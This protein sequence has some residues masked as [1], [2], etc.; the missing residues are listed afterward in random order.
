MKA[1]SNG[2]RL[3]AN[4][5]GL[6]ARNIGFARQSTLIQGLLP[7]VN[8][9]PADLGPSEKD[10]PGQAL[11]RLCTVQMTDDQLTGCL[12]KLDEA[13]RSRIKGQDALVKVMIMSLVLNEHALLEGLPGVGKTEIVKWIACCT[14]LPFSRVQFIPDML[15]SDLIGKDH[16]DIVQLA[17]LQAV[18][19]SAGG[20]SPGQENGSTQSGAVRWINGPIFSSLVLADEINRAPSK[21]QAALLEAMGEKQVTPF[22]KAS[23]PLFSSLHQAALEYWLERYGDRGLLGVPRPI[24]VDRTDLAQFTVFATMNPIEQEGTYPLSEAQIDRFCFKTIVPYPGRRHYLPIDKA[25]YGGY[26][27]PHALEVNL[28][29]GK[30][31]QYF[32]E[33]PR[34]AV[35]VLLPL[36]FFLLCRAHI[37]PVRLGRDSQLVWRSPMFDPDRIRAE[38]PWLQK[39]HDIVYMSNA[40][41]ERIGEAGGSTRWYDHEQVE[42]RG[43]VYGD[44]GQR[45][46]LPIDNRDKLASVFEQ[47]HTQYVKSG[48][49]PRGFLK[50]LSAT[51]CHALLSGHSEPDDVDIATVVGDVLRHRVHMDVHARLAGMTSEDVVHKVCEILL[52]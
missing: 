49:S 16:I 31:R 19:Q 4:E 6:L 14:G 48:G 34:D 8:V 25:V 52:G 44:D 21:V 30:C 26:E 29:A 32:E 12:G 40:R 1:K 18:A 47:E 36:Y 33:H 22:G 24:T 50:L 43:Y 28:P 17:R 37:I 35:V 38:K 15:P 13:F 3:S 39:L 42:M 9:D 46:G 5:R 11:D 27:P 45:A 2:E 10:I 7:L 51:L 20:G 23:M 41:A